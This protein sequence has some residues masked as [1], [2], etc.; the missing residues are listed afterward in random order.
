MKLFNILQPD[1]A[2]FGSK[3]FQQAVIIKKMV[4]DLQLG[5]KVITGPI[6]R[7][8]DGLA[9]SSRNAYLSKNER[10]NAVTLYQSLKWL[11]K[12]YREG[13]RNPREGFIKMRRMIR[14]KGGRIDYI[15]MVDKNTLEPV[16]KLKKGTLVALAVYFG[17]TRLID[18]VIL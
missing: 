12:A 6:V 3:D 9:M 17:R 15:E 1:I 8:P 13:L 5:V 18:N 2:V 16:K 14:G 4:R 10:K 11:K 7:E